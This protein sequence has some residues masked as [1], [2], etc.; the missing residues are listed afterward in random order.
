E[1]WAVVLDGAEVAQHEEGPWHGRFVHPELGRLLEEL[2][3]EATP[4]A[5]VL[6]TRF[7]LPTLERRPFAR[8]LS[9]AGLDAASARDL[10]SSLGVQGAA[11]D[12]DAL[13]ALAGRHA[14]A[15]ELL[16]TYAVRFGGGSA[17]VGELPAAQLPGASEEEQR[18]ARV[19]AAFQQALP[20][21]EQD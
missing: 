5:V 1:R 12:L 14:K 10:L 15:V 3:S 7:P 19:M 21:E 11:A 18:V 20:A 17:R 4:G 2:A 16:G 6:T 13:A 9:L 8:L